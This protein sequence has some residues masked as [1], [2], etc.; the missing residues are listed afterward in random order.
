VKRITV[1]TEC[2]ADL[3]E[4]WTW[5]VPDEAA[6]EIAEL[7]EGE[8]CD[9]DA[10]S[11]V[12]DR[13]PHARFRGCVDNADNEMDRVTKSVE[14]TD[15]PTELFAAKRLHLCT[16]QWVVLVLPDKREVIVEARGWGALASWD[17]GVWVDLVEHKGREGDGQ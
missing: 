15:A 3:T 10:V 17:L 14:I 8:A 12:I 4:T 9:L 6:A 16:G 7:R 2:Q 1:D 11:A 13:H 5:D